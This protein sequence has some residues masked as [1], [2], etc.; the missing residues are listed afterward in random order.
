MVAK[1]SPVKSFKRARSGIEPTGLAFKESTVSKI[2]LKKDVGKP[3]NST[4]TP[5]VSE[6][7]FDH[8]NNLHLIRGKE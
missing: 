3:L 4:N 2:F 8:A 1:E 6:D 5:R 7:M